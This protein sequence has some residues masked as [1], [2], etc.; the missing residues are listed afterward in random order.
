MSVKKWRPGA[1]PSTSSGQMARE[2]AE[3][4]DSVDRLTRD[5]VESYAARKGM[6]IHESERWLSANLGY[7]A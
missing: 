3:V 4:K 1:P 5:Q 6:P 2:L 7:D